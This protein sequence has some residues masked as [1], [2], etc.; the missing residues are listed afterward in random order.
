MKEIANLEIEVLVPTEEYAAIDP[1]LV[2]WPG[3]VNAMLN[4]LHDPFPELERAIK[5]YNYMEKRNW[6]SNDVLI[7]LVENG[8]YYTVPVH[9]RHVGITV[10]SAEL[11]EEGRSVTFPISTFPYSPVFFFTYML[12]RQTQVGYCHGPYEHI[13]EHVVMI[14]SRIMKEM[15]VRGVS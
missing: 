15:E 2:A 8:L 14:I 7:T 3:I 4:M 1:G 11:K 6:G 12:S 5:H 9:L 13:R 10:C